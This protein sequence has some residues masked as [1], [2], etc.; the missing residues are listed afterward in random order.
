[1]SKS[2]DASLE[3]LA[4][5][6]ARALTHGGEDRVAREHARGR[7]SA[8]ERVD[9][10]LDA[11]S[12]QE[13]GMLAGF[14]TTT[15]DGSAK[16]TLPSSLVCGFGRVDGR[17]VAVGAE[18]YTVGMG[19]WTGLYL[20]KSKGIFPGYIESLA[21]EWQIPLVLF[22]QSVGGDV[23]SPSEGAMNALPSALSSAPIFDL[24]DLVPSVCAVMGPTAGGSAVRAACSHLSLMSRPNACLF[25]GG[26]PLVEHGLGQKVDK[27]TLGGDE[28][29]TRSSGVID[30][31]VDSEQETVD[32]IR[33]FLS[34]LPTNVHALPPRAA[35][36]EDDPPERPCEVLDLIDPDRPR[37]PVDVRALIAEIFDRGS[38]FE[39]G[40][41][42]GRALVTGLSRLGGMSVGVLATDGQ[43]D[44]G[45][46]TPDA[47]EKQ[48][49]LV[50]LCDT[51]HLPVVYLADSPGVM[52]GVKAERAGMLRQAARALQALHRASVP[53]VTVHVRRTFGLGTMAAGSPDRL[54]IK[55]AWPSVLQ[56]A[57]GLPIEGAAAVLYKHEIARA[58]DPEKAQR[59]IQQRLLEEVSV[60]KCAESFGVED[61]ID[62]RETRR[63]IHRWL[64]TATWSQRAGPKHG[65]QYRL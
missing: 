10:L 23:D 3:E 55:L 45:A 41:D 13:V 9:L 48:R 63:V 7:L 35:V 47:A 34:F 14:R 62:P 16:E 38:F 11:G 44:G 6:R 29:H 57:M 5:R 4:R 61:L 50:E 8:R 65:P 51:F 37:R 36:G 17:P 54:S 20:E 42:W 26:P 30:N 46:L 25:A 24:L 32:Q 19:T 52:I 53:V 43:H 58:E 39:I 59:E 60:W 49:R 64:E 33:R 21:H 18:D 28:M 56:G 15:P 27:F 22:L 40:P 31:A 1:M 12:F 2:W